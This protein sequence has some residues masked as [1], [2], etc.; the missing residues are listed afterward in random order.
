MNVQADPANTKCRIRALVRNI[1]EEIAP[2]LRR[3]VTPFS[4]SSALGPG[5]L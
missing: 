4:I 3:S 1:K 2:C 5:M